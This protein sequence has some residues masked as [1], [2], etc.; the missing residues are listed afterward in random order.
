MKWWE[1]RREK[2]SE[3]NHKEDA[4][5]GEMEGNCVPD[6]KQFGVINRKLNI[7]WN[8]KPLRGKTQ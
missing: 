8:R 7:E 3:K 4:I 2:K 5:Y 1:C 6:F